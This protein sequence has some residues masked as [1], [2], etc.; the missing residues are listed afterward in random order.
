MK[1]LEKNK[2]KQSL[3]VQIPRKYLDQLELK[4]TQK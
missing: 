4:F 2:L 1:I 3:V